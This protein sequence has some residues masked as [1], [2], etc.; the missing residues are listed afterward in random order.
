M[1]RCWREALPT[2]EGFT[3]WSHA[4]DTGDNRGTDQF[5]VLLGQKAEG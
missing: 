1:Y 3:A 4:H 5:D 2:N